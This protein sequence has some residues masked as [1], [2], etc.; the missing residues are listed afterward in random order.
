MGGGKHIHSAK[1]SELDSR[2]LDKKGSAAWWPLSH[3]HKHSLVICL[4]FSWGRKNIFPEFLFSFYLPCL[5]IFI[6]CRCLVVFP[7]FFPIFPGCRCCHCWCFT[8]SSAIFL[9]F[10]KF[11]CL[12][13]LFRL[14]IMLFLSCVA[15]AVAV[16]LAISFDILSVFVVRRNEQM[17][18]KLWKHFVPFKEQHFVI[19]VPL[20]VLYYKFWS[21]EKPDIR[22]F[23][24][25]SPIWFLFVFLFLVSGFCCCAC[26]VFL[27]RVVS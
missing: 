20:F 17:K 18:N 22:V 23:V 14:H 4:T 3:V 8:I 16:V 21:P 9:I 27:A 24:A 5:F 15:V 6:C 19:V 2:G 10:C 1:K 12:P 26:G 11:F 13:S 25:L 7:R